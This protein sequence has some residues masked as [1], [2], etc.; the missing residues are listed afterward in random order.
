MGQGC[1]ESKILVETARA[2][3]E[4]FDSGVQEALF[5]LAESGG[6]SRTEASLEALS[7]IKSRSQQ[8]HRI[9]T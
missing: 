2:A 3:P 9:G 1:E 7:I 5:E 4:K 6:G 8:A